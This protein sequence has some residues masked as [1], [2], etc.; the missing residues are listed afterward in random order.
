[1][2]KNKP[3]QQTFEPS[4]QIQSINVAGHRH[5]TPQKTSMQGSIVLS[6]AGKGLASKGFDNLSIIAHTKQ[7]DY[8]IYMYKGQ[9]PGAEIN[10]KIENLDLKN[11]RLSVISQF[12]EKDRGTKFHP[13]FAAGL[14]KN[15]VSLYSR[16]TG[17][18]VGHS[19][20]TSVTQNML[21]PTNFNIR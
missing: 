7:P 13:E 16:K 3:I 6:S 15:P 20:A 5:F 10:K 11:K 14:S 2:G 1:M 17:D 9:K 8:K 4:M 19:A 12:H 21:R 18:F